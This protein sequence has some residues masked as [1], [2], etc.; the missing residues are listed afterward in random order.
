MVTLNRIEAIK[1]IHFFKGL[2]D[3]ELDQVAALCKEQSLGIGEMFQ[4]DG[5]ADNQL[6]VILEGKIATVAHIP[7]ISYLKSEVILDVL[8]DGDVFGWSYLLKSTPLSTLRVID[9]TRILNINA[10]E[11]LDLCEANYHIGFIVMH[12]LSSLITSKL[13]RNRISMLNAI[14]A[15]KGEC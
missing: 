2:T 3:P 15:I 4:A 6:H 9:P 11:L 1:S 14:V 10:E 5:K 7:N 12:N 13:R 8:R